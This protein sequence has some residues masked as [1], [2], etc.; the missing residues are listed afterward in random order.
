MKHITILI[1]FLLY[2]A[3]NE[4]LFMSFAAVWQ[5][6][7]HL[8]DSYKNIYQYDFDLIDLP[9]LFL[10]KNL[11]QYISLWNIKINIYLVPCFSGD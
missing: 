9:K 6:E 10:P 3:D 8:K 5:F 2:I 1:V 4:N 11:R 7:K